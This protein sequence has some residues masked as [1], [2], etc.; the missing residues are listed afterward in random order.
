MNWNVST[1]GYI[2]DMA[3]AVLAA[4]KELAGTPSWGRGNRV[5]EQR[6]VWPILINGE[7]GP[8]LNITAY[9]KRRG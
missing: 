4:D 9:P 5:E 7:L 8:Q 6:L 2:A 3:D 1:T